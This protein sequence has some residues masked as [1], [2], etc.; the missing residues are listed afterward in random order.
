M[1]R[2]NRRRVEFGRRLKL[3]D[4][5]GEL[6]LDIHRVVIP[7]HGHCERIGDEEVAEPRLRSLPGKGSERARRVKFAAGAGLVGVERVFHRMIFSGC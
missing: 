6:P 2:H 1:Q 3:A 7:V 5:T 4:A